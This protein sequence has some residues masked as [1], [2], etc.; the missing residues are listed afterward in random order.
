MFHRIEA[1]RAL[2]DYIIEVRFLGGVVKNYDTKIIA[3]SIPQFV[4]L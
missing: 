2:A 1:V 4:E 3:D